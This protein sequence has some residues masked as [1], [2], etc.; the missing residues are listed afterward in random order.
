MPSINDFLPPV[1][2]LTEQPEAPKDNPQTDPPATEQCE[3]CGGTGMGPWSTH[4]CEVCNG[5]GE[6]LLHADGAKTQIDPPEILDFETRLSW[7]V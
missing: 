2:T 1:S 3:A 7:G 4:G 5:V 6:Y